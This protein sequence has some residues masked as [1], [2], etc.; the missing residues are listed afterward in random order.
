MMRFLLALLLAAAAA[1]ACVNET[2]VET[3]VPNSK[4]RSGNCCDRR[5]TCE[6]DVVFQDYRCIPAG[7]ICGGRAQH[8]AALDYDAWDRTTQRHVRPGSREGIAV[9]VVDYA[10]C[11]AS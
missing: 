9:N 11:V 8:G 5:D 6:Y 3:C 2:C 4:M 7:K 10:G 1:R